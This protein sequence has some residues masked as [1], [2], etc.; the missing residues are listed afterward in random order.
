MAAEIRLFWRFE[1][2]L[3]GGETVDLPSQK[4]RALLAILALQ[5][6]AM[7]S[8][9]RLAGL[10]WGERG[11]PQ[12]RDNLKHA[13]TRLHQCIDTPTQPVIVSDRQYVGVDPSAVTVDVAAFERLLRQGTPDAVERA[14]DLYRGDLLE[15]LNIRDPAFEDWLLAERRRLRGTVEEALAQQLKSLMAAGDR[16]RATSAA[17]RLIS[18]DPLPP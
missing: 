17:R 9:D 3:A 5:P 16:D 10:L 2:R 1:V 11:E 14:S 18:L 12:A 8:R 13:L 4:D 15:D 7:H 6:G